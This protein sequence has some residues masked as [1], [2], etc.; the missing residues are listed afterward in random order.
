MIPT[1]QMDSTSRVERGPLA[2]AWKCLLPPLAKMS[3]RVG[4]AL[5]MPRGKLLTCSAPVLDGAPRSS[6]LRACVR[7]SPPARTP[8]LPVPGGAAGL[9]AGGERSR[10]AS[11]PLPPRGA[12]SLARSLARPRRGALRRQRLLLQSVAIGRRG[13]RRRAPAAARAD[14]GSGKGRYPG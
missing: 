6:G 8:S 4:G 13:G 11:P 14:G 7:A 12:C 10:R 9:A 5:R 3:T 1:F 2:L